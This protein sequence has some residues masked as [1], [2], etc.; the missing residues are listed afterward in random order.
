MATS[1]P[2][3]LTPTHLS[4][5]S[6]GKRAQE[7]EAAQQRMEQNGRSILTMWIIG[8]MIQHHRKDFSLTKKCY[9]IIAVFSTFTNLAESGIQFEC[10]DQQFLHDFTQ[11]FNNEYKSNNVS[12]H[13][14]MNCRDLWKSFLEAF[15]K[16]DG[17]ARFEEKFAAK[18]VLPSFKNPDGAML[19]ISD[20]LFLLEKLTMFLKHLSMHP[21][22]KQLMSIFYESPGF[23]YYEKA[24]LLYFGKKNQHLKHQLR[25]KTS[26]L[27]LT[28]KK[29]KE[30]EQRTKGLQAMLEQEQEDMRRLIEQNGFIQQELDAL[31]LA[32]EMA[33]NVRVAMCP[34]CRTQ[35]DGKC[36]MKLTPCCGNP[37]CESCFETIKVNQQRE[38]PIC[39]T[40][41]K[42]IL[43]GRVPITDNHPFYRRG[44]KKLMIDVGT[45]VE[46]ADF[47]DLEAAIGGPAIDPI[48]KAARE[49]STIYAQLLKSSKKK[50]SAG[51]GGIF[52]VVPVVVPNE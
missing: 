41:R 13:K 37:L 48:Q 47:L 38:N 10:D 14:S 16:S 44:E 23:S 29:L 34:V 17:F 31:K 52:V 39:P 30:E 40:C 20:N 18:I 46:Q 4:H 27:S 43:N 3:I 7:E 19:T 42:P 33:G 2:K 28:E 1:T 6:E 35:D 5:F 45:M 26:K 25:L 24:N 22:L 50:P 49:P 36:G 9:G 12:D 32:V 15:W 21:T 51:E 8:L 11:T